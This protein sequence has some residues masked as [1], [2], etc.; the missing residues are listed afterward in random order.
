MKGG[1]FI[2]SMI[3]DYTGMIERGEGDKSQQLKRLD[4]VCPSLLEI[5]VGEHLSQPTINELTD[6]R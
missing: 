2:L 3:A 5:F 4:E 6:R 1:W